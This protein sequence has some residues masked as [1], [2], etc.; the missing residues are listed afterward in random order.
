MNMQDKSGAAPFPNTGLPDHQDRLSDRARLTALAETG[1]MDSPAEAEFDRM[2]RLATTCLGVPVGL[3]SFVDAGRQAFKAQCGLE[4]KIAETRETPLS[5]SFCQYV[6]AHDRTLAVSDARDHPLL[7]SNPAI[8]ELGVVAYLGVPIHAPTGEPIGSF[9]A[10]DSQPRGW[11]SRDVSV[12][13]DLAAMV[14]TELLLRHERDAMQR[15]AREMN[16]RVK[17]LFS[18]VGGMIAL[19]ARSADSPADM[20]RRLQGRLSALDLAHARISPALSGG[21][22]SAEAVDLDELVESLVSPHLTTGSQQLDLD[23][24]DLRL[25]GR[26]VTD[27]ALVIHE[28]ATNAAKYGALSTPDGKV[29]LQGRIDGDSIRLDWRETGGPAID[30]VPSDSG[31]GS[32]LISATIER[33]MNGTLATRWDRSGVTHA[34]T[35]P[36]P[37]FET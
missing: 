7:R 5:R 33:Q 22:R 27:L 29:T 32:R 15:L 12:L 14:E 37:V 23:L 31:F 10:I 2:T 36:R 1:V 25:A 8:S 28:L 21:R 30:T 9:C 24:P 3:A 19:T 17:N 20:A 6:V 11:T 34:L 4:G 35:L 13:T 26:S 16:H 18:V